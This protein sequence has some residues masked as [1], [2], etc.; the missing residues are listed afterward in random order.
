MGQTQPFLFIFVIFSTNLTINYKSVDGVLGTQT[1]GG[2]MVGEDES[3]ELWGTP[4]HE[5]F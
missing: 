2:R 3:T 4:I 5:S 1:Q